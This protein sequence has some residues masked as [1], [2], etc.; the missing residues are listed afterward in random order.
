MDIDGIIEQLKVMKVP[1]ER[2]I[3]LLLSLCE[4]IL[5]GEGNVVPIYA[6]VT[7][8]GD[9]HGQLPDLVTICNE[10]SK[11]PYL[12]LGDYVDRGAYSVETLLLLISLKVRDPDMVT[13]LRGNHE[14]R[15]ITAVYGFYD[16]C[17]R[18]FSNGSS[19]W[20]RCCSLFDY[21]PLVAVIENS[22][23]CVHGGL[24]PMISKINEIRCIDRCDEVPHEGPICDLLW[25]DPDDSMEGEWALS[26]RGAG[27]LFGKLA[28]E[29]FLHENNFNG[30]ARAHQLAME[31]FRDH[32]NGGVI[33]V[34]SAPNY[35]G[36]CGNVAAV[37]KIDE[38]LNREFVVF[39]GSE[40]TV[41]DAEYFI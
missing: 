21:L 6:P 7:I 39:G 13:L 28:V 32:F 14:S 19:I 17:I 34:W 24:S 9:I 12:F 10:V 41:L 30:V 37:L 20:R 4:E 33:T 8:I 26:P 25:S 11:G 29:R 35:C 31:G 18:K 40:E 36:R 3:F 1:T 23:M 38:K 16:E 27:F 2:E 5:I 22:I 15:Q